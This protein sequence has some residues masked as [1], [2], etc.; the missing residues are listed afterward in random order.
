[1]RAIIEAAKAY[2][3]AVILITHQTKGGQA[4]GSSTLL[5]DV[6]AT[7][8]IERP[9]DVVK[10]DPSTPLRRIYFEKNR[11]G[12]SAEVLF[13]MTSTGYN[14]VQV[15]MPA[16]GAKEPKKNKTTQRLES[17]LEFIKSKK[18][19]TIGEISS[20]VDLP[21]H[22]CYTL[23][24]ELTITGKVAKRGR[25]ESATYNLIKK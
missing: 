7:L 17:V 2:E 22:V 15:E 6:D 3:T 4:R 16:K 10:E 14:F 9:E 20:N 13:E 25:G 19:A 5:H 23:L 1:M 24:R 8:Y 12:A 21:V 11:F 18:Q